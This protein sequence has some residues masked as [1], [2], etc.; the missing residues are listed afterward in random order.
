MNQLDQATQGNAA[1]SEE[2]AASSEEMSA[3]AVLLADLVTDLRTLIRGVGSATAEVKEVP[4]KKK[5]PHQPQ[6]DVKPTL[7]KSRKD[8]ES[9]LPLGDEREGKIGTVSGF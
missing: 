5:R 6:V 7:L 9:V 2:V 8:A 4:R 1:S 3:Q